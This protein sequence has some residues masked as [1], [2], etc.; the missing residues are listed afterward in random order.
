MLA[1]GIN[2][3]EIQATLGPFQHQHDDGH[4]FDL[5]PDSQR[6]AASTFD[7]LLRK[8]LE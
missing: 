1:D 5:M 2:V 8:G 4:H 7:R 6:A 3:K